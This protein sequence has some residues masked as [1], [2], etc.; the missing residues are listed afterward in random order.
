MLVFVYGSLLSGLGNHHVMMNAKGTFITIGKSCN[1]FYLT[2]RTDKEF[3]YMTDIPL[4]S[5]QTSKNIVGEVYEV[6]DEGLTILDVL[7]DYPIEYNRHLIDVKDSQSEKVFNC[8]AYFLE[9][10][11]IM[12]DIKSQF[13]IKYV[14]VLE[15]NWRSYLELS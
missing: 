3:P 2:G 12:E 10:E 11:K 6:T 13:G 8:Y 7:E 5:T 1:K 9:N 4:H 15:G 14:D